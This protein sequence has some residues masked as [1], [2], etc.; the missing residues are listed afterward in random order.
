MSAP[1]PAAPSTAPAGPA[2]GREVR[3][4][5]A[6]VAAFAA[7]FGLWSWASPLSTAAIAPGQVA[8]EGS[9]RVVQHLEGG[10]I[11]EFLVR[12]GDVVSEGQTLLRLDDSQSGAQ[13]DL[14]RVQWDS[15]RAL[16]ARLVAE[17]A[18]KDTIAFPPDL[19]ARRSDPRVAEA[20][21]GQEAI[22][23]NHRRA[24][25]GQLSILRQRVGQLNAEIR[26]MEGQVA[27]LQQQATLLSGEIK[28]T[29]GL[30]AQG[31][32]PRPRLLALQREL[33]RVTGER[34]RTQG[35]IARSRQT[36]GETE[37]Q[38]AQIRNAALNE[39]STQQ[40][41]NQQKIA[42]A[43][44]R[45]RAA[46]DVQQRRDVAAPTA[47]TVTNLRFH[48]VGGVIRP[49]E[50]ILDIVPRNEALVIEARVAPND[51]DIV[52]MGLAAD[53]RLTAF[54]Q[55]VVPLLQGHV[56]YVAAD[57]T[58]DERPGGQPYYRTTIQI[59]PDQM[60]LIAGLRL[61][62]GMP[63]EVMIHAGERTLAEYLVQPVRD[64][65]RR[66]FREP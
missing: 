39:A 47:G 6:I 54:K 58:P 35:Q 34:D 13:A 29:E 1:L 12:D 61:A 49:G 25:D 3:A 40:R 21:A 63:A 30:V 51:I 56:T 36:I 52:G 66:A 7:V 41:D 64:S 14:L 26:G 2:V 50:P 45:L 57:I 38:I 8:A 9:R 32:V 43:E 28:D 20:I 19:L 22:F 37:L 16:D 53:V 10:I 17:L 15:L 23:A 27:G 24:Y 60:A 18:E 31:Y 11:R 46:S 59:D 42:E 55:R 65:F 48:T 4:G 62:S 5:F 33:A 44:E